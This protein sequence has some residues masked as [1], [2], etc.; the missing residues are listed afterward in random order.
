M[1]KQKKKKIFKGA[2][3]VE[4]RRLSNFISKAPIC[5]VGQKVAGYLV[6]DETDMQ[7]CSLLVYVTQEVLAS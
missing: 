7:M 6:G 5:A 2:T 3:I 1:L 4:K